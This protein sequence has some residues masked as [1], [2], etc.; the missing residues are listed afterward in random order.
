MI[1][2]FDMNVAGSPLDSVEYCGIDEFD[3]RTKTALNA[4]PDP[5]GDAAPDEDEPNEGTA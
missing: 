5:S 2:R 4:I 1:S 3:D